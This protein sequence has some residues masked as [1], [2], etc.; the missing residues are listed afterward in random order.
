ML[1]ATIFFLHAKWSSIV[2]TSTSTFKH[3]MMM[4][5]TRVSSL[6]FSLIYS[7]KVSNCYKELYIIVAFSIERQRE[8]ERERENKMKAKNIKRICV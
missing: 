7:L 2:N 5:Q 1:C 3:T 4:M 6:S 8:R